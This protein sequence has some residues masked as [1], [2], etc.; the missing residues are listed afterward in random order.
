LPAPG[1]PI[2]R[3]RFARGAADCI[4]ICTPLYGVVT[5]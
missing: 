5:W 4:V 2:M 3:I 1:A